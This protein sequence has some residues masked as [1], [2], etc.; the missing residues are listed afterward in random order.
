MLFSLGFLAAVL[1]A[2]MIAPALWRRAVRLTRERIE[3]S[4]PLTMNEIQADKDRLRAEF[5]M[6]TRRLE[7]SIQSFRDKAAA[8]IIEIGKS[9]EELRRVGEERDNKSAVLSELEAVATGLR[10][11]LKKREEELQDL[12]ARLAEADAA[13]RERSQELEAQSR[14]LSAANL[15]TSN[16]RIELAARETEIEK[17]ASDVELMRDERR[18]GER[19]M[20]ESD[21][22]RKAMEEALKSERRRA[23]ALDKKLERLMAT[24]ADRE[25]TLERREAELARLREQVKGMASD[26][27]GRK[28]AE[29]EQRHAA[30]EA[31]LAEMAA[32]FDS[33]LSD[34]GKADQLER[35]MEKLESEREHL[36]KRLLAMVR[37]NKKL[38][39]DLEAQERAQSSDWTRERRESAMLREQINDLAAEVVQLTALLEGPDSP[40][41]KALEMPVNGV[42]A[43]GNGAHAEGSLAPSLADR[44]R[45]L[46]KTPHIR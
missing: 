11:E 16:L 38:R 2:L 31:E 33:L 15:D 6:S 25:E 1:I 46:Q 12:A 32:K 9:R 37:E 39:A 29:A 34:G 4:T 8:Q 7:M 28:L 35:A 17:L 41:S 19:R 13:F 5:A 44:I 21:A 42:P 43:S 10:S 40:I 26:D 45:A 14:A 3:A 20:R 36:E 24:V 27:S 23:S 18:E 22:D 30:L